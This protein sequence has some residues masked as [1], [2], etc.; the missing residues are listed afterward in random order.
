MLFCV[1]RCLFPSLFLCLP[2]SPS[3]S[4]P[5]SASTLFFNRLDHCLVLNL[6]S[7]GFRICLLQSDYSEVHLFASLFVEC[8]NQFNSCPDNHSQFILSSSTSSVKILNP[9]FE[10][11]HFLLQ[12]SSGNP[13]FLSSNSHTNEW[14]VR[15][16]FLIQNEFRIGFFR[17]SRPRRIYS[18]GNLFEMFTEDLIAAFG[19]WNDW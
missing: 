1:F 19:E 4:F 10:S 6:F 17:A 16:Q 14:G 18:F 2:L 3:T 8:S 15:P 11:F 13:H 5:T 7:S 9:S 12:I